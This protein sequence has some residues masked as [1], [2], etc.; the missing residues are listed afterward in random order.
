V[1]DEPP[2]AAPYLHGVEVKNEKLGKISAWITNRAIDT[3]LCYAK[4]PD[5]LGP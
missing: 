1:Y 5:V 2:P 3:A 4:I